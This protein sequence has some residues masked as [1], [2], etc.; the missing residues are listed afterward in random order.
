MKNNLSFGDIC[1]RSYANLDVKRKEKII[2]ENNSILNAFV[3]VKCTVIFLL[4]SL[5]LKIVI[6]VLK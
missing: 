1:E 3:S 5:E 2:V 6:S 4:Y